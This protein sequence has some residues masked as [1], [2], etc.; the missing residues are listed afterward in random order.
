[1]F[2][3]VGEAC[4]AELAGSVVGILVT[5]AWTGIVLFPVAFGA[6]ADSFGYR[7]SW[8]MV[9][10]TAAVSMAA[11]TYSYLRKAKKVAV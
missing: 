9:A 3:L 8:T 6:I 7:W 11:Y 1:L 5:V 4:G 10:V 2:A